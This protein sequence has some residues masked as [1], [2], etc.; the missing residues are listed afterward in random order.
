MKQ[1]GCG[2]G[3]IVAFLGLVLS[4][5]LFPYLLSSIYA[6][7]TALLDVPGTPDWLWGDWLSTVIGENGI[8]YMVLAEGPICCVGIIALLIVV[9]GTVMMIGGTRGGEKDRDEE[10]YGPY[11]KEQYEPYTEEEYEPYTEEEY[12]PYTEEG[13]DLYKEPQS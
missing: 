9:L 12:E 6:L 11:T 5:C 4:L 7:I 10:E 2:L 3:C 1:R 8:L 13:Y